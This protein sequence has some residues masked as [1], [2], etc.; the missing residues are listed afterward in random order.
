MTN[1][2]G[3]RNNHTKKKYLKK[4]KLKKLFKH[5]NLKSHF[6]IQIIN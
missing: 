1:G 2:V 3:A 4:E 5:L 6:F